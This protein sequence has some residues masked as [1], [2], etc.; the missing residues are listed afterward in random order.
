M[1][2]REFLASSLAAGAGGG[3]QAGTVMAQAEQSSP[4]DPEFYELRRYH[5]RVGPMA[6][7]MH[8]YLQNVSIPALNRA[9]AGPV[10]AFTLQFG[11]ETPAIYLLLAFKSIEDFAGL[12]AKL[13]AD[14]AYQKA[15]ESHA[16]LPA[17][18]PAYVRIDSRLMRADSAMPKLQVPAGAAGNKP[19]VFE[20]R[21]Y[22]SHSRKANRTKREMFGKGGELAIFR[23][24]GLTPVFFA[25]DLIGDRLPSLT[26]MLVFDDLASREHNWATFAGDAE[27]KKLR[28]T[29]GYTDPEIVSNITSIILRPTA[30]SQV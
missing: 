1:N 29:P 10:G 17:S 30:Y 20:L 14:A 16:N 23:R 9:G 3:L 18:D 15:A 5:L 11:P 2:R 26:Y 13:T 25:E 22:E 6:A 12:N 7:R 24:T 4:P 27:W 21:T 8:E 19:R 28:S